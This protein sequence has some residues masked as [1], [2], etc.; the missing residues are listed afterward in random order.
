MTST[1]RFQYSAAIFE[2]YPTLIGGVIAADHLQN[3]PSPADFLDLYRAEQQSV[4]ARIGDTPLSQLPSLAAW[5]GVF[6]SFGVDP[7]QIRSACEALLR[8]LTKQGD[9]PSINLLVD[10]GNLVS[11]RYGLPVAIMDTRSA[12]GTITVKFA[13]GSE[14]FTNLN[15]VEI[16]HP[17][18]G[19]VIFADEG[20]IVYARRWCWRQS[21]QSATREETT[22][23]IITVEGH[24]DTARTDIE[25]AV[26]DLTALIE[27][28]AGGTLTS[29][30]LDA[31]QRTF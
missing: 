14:S 31:S 6:R 30:L 13:N 29:G 27:R 3:R 11:I 10:I 4:L 5:R 8:R 17:E 28:F 15:A 23:A 21:D 16:D 24:H 1:P 26:H 2:R 9:I 20:D 7:T 12:Q 19:E 22:T 25:R 18:A